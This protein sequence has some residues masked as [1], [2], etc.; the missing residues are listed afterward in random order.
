MACL[1]HLRSGL[2]RSPN[3]SRRE[4]ECSP[5][6][7][8]FL[9]PKG[10]RVLFRISSL[11]PCEPAIVPQEAPILELPRRLAARSDPL[12][13]VQAGAAVVVALDLSLIHISEPTRLRRI[14]YAVFCLKKKKKKK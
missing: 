13:V 6:A 11:G 2:K 14:S 3:H 10:S 1:V 5:S 7:A 9:Y 8:L 4:Q 12:R